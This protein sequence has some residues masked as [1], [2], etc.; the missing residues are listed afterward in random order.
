MLVV[1]ISGCVKQEDPVENDL[2]EYI[3]NIEAVFSMEESVNEHFASVS[4]DNHINP[5]TS[6]DVL[7][8]DIIP[9]MNNVRTAAGN[10][11][12]STPTV[13]NLHRIYEQYLNDKYL[14]LL[15]FSEGLL[16]VDTSKL[17]SAVESM[18]RANEKRQE[19]LDGIDD[20]F[21]EYFQD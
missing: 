1:N 4:G 21:Y 12:P 6:Y 19:Y 5:E 13:R 8:N 17:H 2:R 11:N 10:I 14:S 20:L 15:S 9:K 3:Q 18:V 16:P 7:I